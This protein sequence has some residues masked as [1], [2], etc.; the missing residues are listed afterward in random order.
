MYKNPTLTELIVGLLSLII[1]IY[2]IIVIMLPMLKE[3]IKEKISFALNVKP[4]K[5]DFMNGTKINKYIKR[6]MNVT[7]G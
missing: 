5:H 3:G 1:F 2:R 6:H 4:K 7:G